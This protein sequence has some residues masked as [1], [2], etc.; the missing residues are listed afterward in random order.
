MTRAAWRGPTQTE[1]GT[2]GQRRLARPAPPDSEA[3]EPGPVAAWTGS[4]AAPV[5]PAAGQSG[6]RCKSRGS[7]RPSGPRCKSRGGARAA[8]RGESGPPA[9][10]KRG[11]RAMSVLPRRR[12]SRQPPPPARRRSG[13]GFR[14]RHSCPAFRS[15]G[16][17]GGGGGGGSS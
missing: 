11:L 17:G 13:R 6:P 12:A 9:A 4:S 5:Q 8:A 3:A 10:L 7:Q 14:L 2:P 1:Q 15:S 16:G